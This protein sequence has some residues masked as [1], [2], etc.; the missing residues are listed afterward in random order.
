MLPADENIRNQSKIANLIDFNEV[1]ELVKF[2][3]SKKFDLHRAGLSNFAGH[4]KQFGSI[5][6]LRI[7]YNSPK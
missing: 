6:Y 1:F 2:T 3:V 7:K 5:S 4:A